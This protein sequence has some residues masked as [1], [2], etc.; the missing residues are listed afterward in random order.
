MRKFHFTILILA[1]STIAAHARIRWVDGKGG[2]APDG[3]PKYHT[4]HD[5]ISAS[6]DTQPPSVPIDTVRILPGIYSESITIDKNVIVQGGGFQ[7][8]TITSDEE[9]TVTMKT[10][11]LMWVKISNTAG[12]GVHMM[13]GILTNSVVMN[14]AIS[15]VV[16]EGVAK[17]YFTISLMNG[18]AGFLQKHSSPE[19][20]IL[21]CISYKN[22]CGWKQE[23]AGGPIHFQYSCNYGNTVE[24]EYSGWSYSYYYDNNENSDPLFSSDGSLRPGNAKL[25]GKGPGG[26]VDWDGSLCDMGYYGGLDAPLLPYVD[27]PGSIKLNTDG[28]IQFEMSGRVGY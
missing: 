1:L 2:T 11:K 7:N 6:N 17:A 4:I 8:T 18:G 12:S 16:F 20:F 22:Y 13:G 3:F 27:L 14:C 26:L 5:A 25:Y 21:G 23:Y 24:K 10:G 9:Y 28:T 15:G 19:C